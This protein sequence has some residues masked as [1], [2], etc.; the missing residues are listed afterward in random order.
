MRT[1]YAAAVDWID[2]ALVLPGAADHPALW[3]QVLSDKVWSLRWLGRTAEQPALMA[4]A[5]AIAREAGDPV[6][7]SRILHSCANCAT[8]AGR[9]ELGYPLAE[10]ALRWALIA[11][12][13]WEIAN[14]WSAKAD[15]THSIGG[16]RAGAE[17]AASL[18]AEVGNLHQLADLLNLAA[19][20]A[21]CLG[22][23]RDA[24][25]F[26]DR[27]TPI[28]C[29]LGY[30]YLWMMLR[31]NAGLVA[32]FTGDAVAATVAFRDELMLCRELVVHPLASEGF[33]GLAGIATVRGHDDRAARLV[34]AASA[35]AH[36]ERQEEIT[37]RLE[38]AFFHGARSRYGVESWDAAVCEGAAMSFED[39]IAYALDQ[40]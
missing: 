23:D 4:E 28:A 12:D 1:R 27:A 9:P 18:L 38:A 30:P 15:A 32:L 35:H 33:L 39:A 22:S 6:T 31:G 3:V 29:L 37:A 13:E 19:Y 16:L 40:G 11:G 8:V 5:Q 36:G 34:G 20:T 25:E 24:A 2:R 14:A 26:L 10:E 21:L 17:R 7:L